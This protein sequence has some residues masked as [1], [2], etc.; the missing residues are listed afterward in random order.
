MEHAYVLRLPKTQL[1]KQTWSLNLNGNINLSVLKC[2][3]ILQNKHVH[4][5]L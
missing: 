1:F 4:L 5:V 2:D 3:F